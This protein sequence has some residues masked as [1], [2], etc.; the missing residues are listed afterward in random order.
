MERSR[1]FALVWFWTVL[2]LLVYV[3][4]YSRLDV[5]VLTNPEQVLLNGG[6]HHSPVVELPWTTIRDGGNITPQL[7]SAYYD[8]RDMSGRPAVVVLGYHPLAVSNMTM[9]CKLTFSSKTTSTV[10]LKN[11]AIKT[12][13]YG[14]SYVKNRRSKPTEYICQLECKGNCTDESIPVLVALSS[15]ADCTDASADIPVR[16]RA[17][18]DPTR[19]KGFGVC[20]ETPLFR[21]N[22]QQFTEFVEMNR[23]LGAR[24]ITFYV[25]HINKQ[26]HHF[27][28]TMYCED[29]LVEV[30]KWRNLGAWTEMHYY[31]ELLIMQDCLYRHMNRVKYVAFE[32]MDELIL[33]L[34]H[35]NWSDMMAVLD[36]SP[37][38]GAF[39]FLNTYFT[40][41]PKRTGVSK[42]C[43]QMNVPIYFKWTRRYL[44]KY[45]PHRRSKFIAKPRLVNALDIHAV[46]TLRGY[47]EY[48]VPYNTG[49]SAH[50]RY[51]RT[52]D[53]ANT[54]TTVDTTALK[55]QSQVMRAVEQKICSHS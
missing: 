46:S 39:L 19:M 40:N 23:A 12:L 45:Q 4:I 10:C 43:K 22:S 24:H 7:F 53:C 55:Y 16:N 41:N 29:D 54:N 37:K 26:L 2:A 25:I 44:C 17:P 31:G 5:H 13:I 48:T 3:I 21:K 27:F 51:Q 1:C 28:S 15:I 50:Y 32:D 52:S 47:F 42:P 33:P 18:R 14:N 8:D 36:T 34:N 49:A 38:R 9:Y 6:C 30:V 35:S 20:V 11:P